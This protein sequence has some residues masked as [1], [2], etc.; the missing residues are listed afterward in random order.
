M[1][2]STNSQIFRHLSSVTDPDDFDPDP[3]FE[4]V[5]IR[6]LTSINLTNECKH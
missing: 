5:W 3:T 1:E 4:N 2:M 6:I